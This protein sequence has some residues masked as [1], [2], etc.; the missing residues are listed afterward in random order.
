M[1]YFAEANEIDSKRPFNG[2]SCKKRFMQHR[3]CCE[4]NIGEMQWSNTA[5]GSERMQGRTG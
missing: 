2:V 3:K 5:Q 4:A 1:V